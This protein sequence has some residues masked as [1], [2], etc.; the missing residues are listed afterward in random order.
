MPIGINRQNGINQTRPLRGSTGRL[1]QNEEQRLAMAKDQAKVASTPQTKSVAQVAKAAQIADIGNKIVD[2]ARKLHQNGYVYPPNLTSQYRHVPGKI[3]CCADFVC[4]SYKEA[5]FDINKDMSSKGYNPHYCPSMIKYFQENQTLLQPNAKTQVGDVVFFDWDGNGASDPDHV[6]VVTKVDDQGRPTELMESRS[7]NQPTEVTTLSWNP[8]DS[9]AQK[10]VGY[11][12]LKDATADNAAANLLPPLANTGAP[13]GSTTPR[14]EGGNGGPARDYGPVTSNPRTSPA[15]TT[16][17]EP[18]SGNYRPS[19]SSL[20]LVLAILKA[21]GI[22]PE[23]IDAGKLQEFADELAKNPKADV[24]ELVKKLGI[25]IPPEQLEALQAKITE[26]AAEFEEA[27]KVAEPA[28]PDTA[29]LIGKLSE[30][31]IEDIFKER[32]SPLAGQGL[33]K[34]VLQ[35][36]K[37]YGVPAAQFLAMGT[38]ESQLGGVGFTQGEH[39]NIGNIRPGSSWEGPTV[40]GGSGSYRSYGN[41][42]E[43][44]EDYF[45]L[46]SGPL[47]KGKTLQEQIFTYAPPSENDSSGY[48]DT[49]NS[50]INGWTK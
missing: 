31:K 13:R 9:R 45:K 26:N 23:G 47:Y 22:D 33:G 41:W 49:V 16:S 48:V 46:L 11:G 42:Q 8:P 15:S 27:G 28:S 30:Q 37:K 40:T 24:A 44:I 6:A 5:G 21:L 20:E 34:F 32:N 35:M 19:R 14:S 4:D 3:G 25:D 7:F 29:A 12:R 36:E 2:G 50:L 18:G 39:H 43:G 38:M 17:T 10:I 1:P